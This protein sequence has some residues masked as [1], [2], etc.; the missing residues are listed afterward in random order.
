M[1]SSLNQI[2]MSHDSLPLIRAFAEVNGLKL[3]QGIGY[4]AHEY[5]LVKEADGREFPRCRYMEPDSLAI[6]IDGYE[7]GRKEQAPIIPKRGRK[8]SMQG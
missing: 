3:Q 4:H 5:Q 2:D 7:E 1:R 6:W 8:K